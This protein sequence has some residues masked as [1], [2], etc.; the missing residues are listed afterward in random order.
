M[1]LETSPCRFAPHSNTRG[2][3]NYLVIVT[4]FFFTVRRCRGC[5]GSLTGGS[6]ERSSC[7]HRRTTSSSRRIATPPA[8]RRRR[9]GS[10]L[11][12][13]RPAFAYCHLE[14]SSKFINAIFLC[15]TLLLNYSI[16]REEYS[17]P[18]SP[19]STSIKR[20]QASTGSLTPVDW[21]LALTSAR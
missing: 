16:K 7:R 10:R 15:K 20:C 19:L 8:A 21:T 11:F 13:Q 2:M 12:G 1:T 18:K 5:R 3:C 14:I 9:F 6:A 17:A 4:C